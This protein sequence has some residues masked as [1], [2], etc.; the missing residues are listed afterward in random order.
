M[1]SEFVDISIGDIKEIRKKLNSLVEICDKENDEEYSL[2]KSMISLGLCCAFTIRFE[3]PRGWNQ[4]DDYILHIEESPTKLVNNDWD[5]I[6]AHNIITAGSV[7]KL[8]SALDEYY[9]VLERRR[10]KMPR[11]V[12]N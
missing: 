5:A 3:A 10:K 6:L 11:Y 9:E 1:A 2:M 7:E 8:M 4:E 12:E